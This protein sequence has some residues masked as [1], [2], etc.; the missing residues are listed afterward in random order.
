MLVETL[1]AQDELGL[2]PRQT[3]SSSDRRRVIAASVLVAAAAIVLVVR[4]QPEWLQ[5]LRGNDPQIEQII[6]AV[7]EERYLEPRLTGGFRYGPLRTLTRGDTR[8]DNLALRAQL[9]QLRSAAERSP[10]ARSLHALGIVELLVGLTDESIDSLTRAVQLSDRQAEFHAD[11][12]AAL[13]VR[14]A[15]EKGSAGTSMARDS[16]ARALA[17]EPR[18]VEALYSRALI[19][20][21]DGT[22]EQAAQYWREYLQYETSPEW[23]ADAEARLR[24]LKASQ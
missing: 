1:R 19:A 17:L 4:A 11:L 9:A 16:I 20:E 13:I 2:E 21:M 6:A 18:L 14:V 7:G 5:R 22:G 12:G 3:H 8:D 10:D 15:H 23:R 24:R